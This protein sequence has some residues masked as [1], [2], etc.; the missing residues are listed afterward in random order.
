MAGCWGVEIP[1]CQWLAMPFDI[2]LMQGSLDD[3]VVQVLDGI[4]NFPF[5]TSEIGTIVTPDF[6]DGTTNADKTLQGLD[7]GIWLQRSN[8]FNVDSSAGETDK[9]ASV[10]FLSATTPLDVEGTEEVHPRV[11]EGWL[12]R[13]KSGLR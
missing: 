9:D 13:C 1:L 3:V 10:N 12:M 11:C 4:S 7:E 2:F 6:L 5:A 8:I